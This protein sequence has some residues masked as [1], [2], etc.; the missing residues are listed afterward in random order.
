MLQIVKI[1]FKLNRES[2]SDVS[3]KYIF[4]VKVRV[5]NEINT[6]RVF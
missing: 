3:V 1:K 2:L 4:Q 6:G 5:D